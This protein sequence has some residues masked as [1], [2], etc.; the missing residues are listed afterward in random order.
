MKD[1]PRDPAKWNEIADVVASLSIPVIANG[2]VFE[3]EDFG[4][5]KNATG[6]DSNYHMAS[7]CIFRTR[8]KKGQRL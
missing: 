4:R 3:Y 1:R 2:D 8:P 6:K 5:M 7:F